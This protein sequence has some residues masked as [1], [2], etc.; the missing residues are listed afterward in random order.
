[1]DT[2]DR[3]DLVA[4]LA[5]RAVADA[6]PAELS[7]FSV[8]AAAYFADPKRAVSG[9]KARPN[10]DEMLGFGLEEAAAI[11]LVTTAALYVAQEISQWASSQVREAVR[12]EASSWIQMWVR[13]V[14]KQIGARR[15][16]RSDRQQQADLTP[17]QLTAIHQ[18]ALKRA[19][20]LVSKSQANTI[21]DSIVAGLVLEMGKE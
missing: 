21:A 8:T 11:P 14:F 6:S 13:R 16:E 17:E 9:A 2:H 4:K 12:E 19:T 10:D 5:R 7:L 20:E 15:K 1:M 18:L 3:R